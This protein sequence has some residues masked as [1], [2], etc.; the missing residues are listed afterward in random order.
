MPALPAA[1]TAHGMGHASQPARGLE[2]EPLVP[3][4]R[5]NQR[6]KAALAHQRELFSSVA[7][8]KASLLASLRQVQQESYDVVEHLRREVVGKDHQLEHLAQLLEQV[9]GRA[10]GRGGGGQVRRDGGGRPS[11]V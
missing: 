6:K 9:G 10:R 3:R 11:R 7:A 4:T 2:P 5:R 8:E 1:R